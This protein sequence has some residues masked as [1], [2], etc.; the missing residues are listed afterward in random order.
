[1]P[2]NQADRRAVCLTHSAILGWFCGVRI[3]FLRFTGFTGFT[4]SKSRNEGIC[5]DTQSCIT[6]KGGGFGFE[7][8]HTFATTVQGQ[9]FRRIPICPS[10]QPEPPYSKLC[11]QRKVE[12]YEQKPCR[13]NQESAFATQKRRCVGWSV[14]VGKGE[15]MIVFWGF[16]MRKELL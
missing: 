13:R 9:R 15:N 2:N 11:P 8:L 10:I 7:P 4:C 12:G 1:M 3:I 16:D 6:R 14:A 5:S